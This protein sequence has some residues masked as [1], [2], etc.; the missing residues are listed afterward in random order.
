MHKEALR[1]T[2]RAS[3]VA[4]GGTSSGELLMSKILKSRTSV[5]TIRDLAQNNA[6]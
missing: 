5:A 2:R 4:E 1:Q 6:P 3:Y